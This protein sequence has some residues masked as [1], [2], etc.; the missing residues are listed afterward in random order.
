MHKQDHD[1]SH[2]RMKKAL[3]KKPTK[4]VSHIMPAP[5]GPR[6]V[7]HRRIREAVAKVFQERA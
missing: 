4:A 1:P 2:E 3:L 6:T 5:K 7:S